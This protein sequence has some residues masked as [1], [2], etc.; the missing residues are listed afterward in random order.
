M[1]AEHNLFFEALDMPF[2]L[3]QSFLAQHAPSAGILQKVYGLLAAHE[4]NDDVLEQTVSR[5][6]T[7][8]RSHI[9]QDLGAYTLT[10]ILAEGGM[11]DVYLARN[12]FDP[13]QKH[14]VKIP[15]R[16]LSNHAH[17]Q[18]LF[19]KEQRLL[20]LLKHTNIVRWHQNGFTPDGTPY[21]AMEYVDGVDLLQ[22]CTQRNRQETLMLFAKICK[23][24][25]FCH[26]QGILHCDLK[27]ENVRVLP[28]GEP[29]LLDFGIAREL[30]NND[31]EPMPTTLPYASPEQIRGEA[32]NVGSDIH[33]L[34]VLL[35]QMMCGRLPKSVPPEG[36]THQTQEHLHLDEEATQQM[37]AAAAHLYMKATAF[38]AHERY[39]SVPAL[40]NDLGLC[41]LA[42][43]P[44]RHQGKSW[45]TNYSEAVA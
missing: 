9:G 24:V 33:A 19:A 22:A 16:N 5:A 40:L 1:I 45:R 10:D 35:H 15:H 3:R 13:N 14:V 2:H 43:Q 11:G 34:G 42:P 25:H 4:S 38:R 27:P 8:N 29:V 20:A 36:R 32:L 23:A 31:P 30:H 39:E 17:G 21:M 37:G 7:R 6:F 12:H 18:A 28:N 26:Q 44:A 41:Y